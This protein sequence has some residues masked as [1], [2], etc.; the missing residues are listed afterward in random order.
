MAGPDHAGLF[1]LA[2]SQAGYFTAEQARGAG[3][4]LR[5][6]QHHA[7]TGRFIRIRRGLYR[8]RDYPSSP[9]E[10]VMAAY[11][12]AGK[13]GAVIS[14]ESAL[15]LLE[16]S[17][18]IPDAIH[19]SVP[20]TKRHLPTL[21]G[22]AVHTTTRPFGREDVAIR[23]GMRVTSPLRTILDTAETG[24]GPEQV[25]QAI[26][27]AVNR[28]LVTPRRLTEAAASRPQRVSRLISAALTRVST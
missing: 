13:E 3:F 5:L 9:R 7:E 17:D 4:S 26:R 19:L 28:G 12:A 14:H 1:G 6:L 20:R 21:P 10:E 8:L 11:L 25:E 27:A 18:T 23:Q 15:D 16:L 24:T 22:V 2:S